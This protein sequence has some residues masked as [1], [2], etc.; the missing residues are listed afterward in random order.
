MAPLTV[1]YRRHSLFAQSLLLF[2]MAYDL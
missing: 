2:Q 1:L